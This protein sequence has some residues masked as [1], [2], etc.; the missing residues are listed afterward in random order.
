[1]KESRVDSFGVVNHFLARYSI[2]LRSCSKQADWWKMDL[3]VWQ[4]FVR[5]LEEALID[6][7]ATPHLTALPTREFRVGRLSDM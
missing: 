7:C 2:R 3:L 6:L 5:Q 1:M 4:I